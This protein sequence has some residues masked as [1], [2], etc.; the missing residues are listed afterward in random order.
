MKRTFLL[1][2]SLA[3]ALILSFSVLSCGGTKDKD[4]ETSDVTTA[5]E[6]ENTTN[7]ET[8][9]ETTAQTTVETSTQAETEKETE[10]EHITNADTQGEETADPNADP[11]KTLVKVGKSADGKTDCYDGRFDFTDYLGEIFNC[12]GVDYGSLQ[13]AIDAAAGIG[14]NIGIVNSTDVGLCLKVTIPDD[15]NFYRFFYNLA[16][17]DILFN[18]GVTYDDDSNPH[19][20]AYYSDIYRLDSIDG[21]DGTHIYVWS[22]TEG[23]APGY[24]IMHEGAS[25]DGDF[26]YR[27]ERIGSL[28]DYW[29][30]LPNGEDVSFYLE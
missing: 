15:G 21:L 2:L 18:Y 28:E 4:Q 17:I 14:G 25:A 27:Y 3:L 30:G 20:Y 10:T 26:N 24:Y 5:K 29:P 22:D 19:G 9:V 6:S 7:K 13:D 23:L 1:V 12:A 8:S 11:S 16:N